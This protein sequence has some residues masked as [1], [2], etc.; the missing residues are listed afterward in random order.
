MAWQPWLGEARNDR[1]VLEAEA[2]M[3][4]VAIDAA[5]LACEEM[6][7]G[8]RQL[9]ADGMMVPDGVVLDGLLTVLKGIEVP[10]G[11]LRAAAAAIVSRMAT[12]ASWVEFTRA[13]EVAYLLT[14]VGFY[15]PAL[16][17]NR[18]SQTATCMRCRRQAGA[19]F[20]VDAL[21]NYTLFNIF[22]IQ[23]RWKASKI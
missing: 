18:G 9:L 5:T 7:D 16:L 22:H 11:E 13:R 20:K 10:R 4:T 6:Y 21:S 15:M 8:A 3:D 19:L 12:A 1:Y 23:Q 17:S 14:T 2:G